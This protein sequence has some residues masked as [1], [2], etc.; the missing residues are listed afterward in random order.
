MSFIGRDFGDMKMSARAK[1]TR[2]RGHFKVGTVILFDL[3]S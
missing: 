3:G 1:G 2:G